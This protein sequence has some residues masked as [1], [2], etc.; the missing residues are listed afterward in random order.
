MKSIFF[1]LIV[2][3]CVM[4]VSKLYYANGCVSI[5]EEEEKKRS[6]T[7]I[8]MILEEL[9]VQKAGKTTIQARQYPEGRR[10]LVRPTLSLQHSSGTYGAIL[11][12]FFLSSSLSP[13]FP[14]SYFSPFLFFYFPPGSRSWFSWRSGVAVMTE[15]YLFSLPNKRL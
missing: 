10:K 12:L 8:C 3:K 14:P 6:P 4:I 9:G 5:K 13:L 2:S 7:W 1:Y 15:A 11:F